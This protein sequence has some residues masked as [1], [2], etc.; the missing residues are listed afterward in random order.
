MSWGVSSVSTLIRLPIAGALLTTK[1]VD[2][3]EMMN[4]IGV[5]LWSGICLL[6]ESCVLNDDEE[7]TKSGNSHMTALSEDGMSWVSA[8]S[9]L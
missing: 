2:G 6:V 3:R 8:V 1:R 7:E 5:Q 9:S 4:F